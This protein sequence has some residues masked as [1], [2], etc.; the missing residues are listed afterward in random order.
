M[1]IYFDN[2]ATTKVSDKVANIVEKVM[3]DDFGN[4]SS[5]HMAGFDAEK[6]IKEA[7]SEIAKILK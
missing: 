2:A 4:P 7:K 3:K 6:Y 5:L 1:S